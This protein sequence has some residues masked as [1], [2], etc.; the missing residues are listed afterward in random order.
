M[1]EVLPIDEGPSNILSAS[2]AQE[3]E[4]LLQ[5][6]R[7]GYPITTAIRQ[8]LLELLVK[9]PSQMDAKLRIKGKFLGVD[10]GK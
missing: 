7:D 10:F 2:E 4:N 8:R 6:I 3:L 5:K 1:P 9:Q